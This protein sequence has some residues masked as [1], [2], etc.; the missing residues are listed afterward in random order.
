MTDRPFPRKVGQRVMAVGTRGGLVKPSSGYAFLR[1]QLDSAA[2]VRSLSDYGHPFAVRPSPWRYRL[3]DS[4]MLQ[5]MFR[6][7]DRMKSIFTS[8]FQ[9]NPIQ[10][11]FRFLDEAAPLPENLQLL[12]S[13]PSTPFLKALIRLKLLG[14]I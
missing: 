5:V 12:A 2:I 8:L 4:I 13:L 3:F 10:R 14:R 11:I 9:N 7:G 1:I 6:Q